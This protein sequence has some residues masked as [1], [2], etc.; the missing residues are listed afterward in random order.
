MLTI[1]SGVCFLIILFT[2]P[3]THAPTI[4]KHKAERKRK[5]TSDLRW[6]APAERSGKPSVGVLTKAI[7]LKPW[8]VLFSEPMLFAITVY[9]SFIYGCLVSFPHLMFHSSYT[10]HFVTD[11]LWNSH[12][13]HL[14][15]ILPPTLTILVSSLRGLPNRFRTPPTVWTWLQ[16]RDHWTHVPPLVDWRCDLLHYRKPSSHLNITLSGA[17]GRSRSFPF[18]FAEQA[19]VYYNPRYIVTADEYH[20]KGLSVP[21][22]ERLPMGVVGG[23]LFAISFFWFGWTSYPSI[24]FW[25]PMLS[26]GCLGLALTLTFVSFKIISDSASLS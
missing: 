6:H 23:I 4:L 16:R 21:P 3:E 7:L 1:F 2:I 8:K 15:S 20:A 17:S 18:I 12:L 11:K 9:M 26:G 13:I 24:S 14:S 10:A 5:E 25:A 22:E 19:Q